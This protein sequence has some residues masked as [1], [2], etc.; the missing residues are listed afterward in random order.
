ME[1]GLQDDQVVAVDEVDGGASS[2]SS[3]G[4]GLKQSA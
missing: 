1:A 3:A 4:G 2:G